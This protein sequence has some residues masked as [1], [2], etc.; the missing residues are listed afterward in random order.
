M[1]ITIL[2]HINIYIYTHYMIIVI[3]HVY[4]PHV[5]VPHIHEYLVKLIV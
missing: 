1:D 5:H 3:M 2:T 4:M